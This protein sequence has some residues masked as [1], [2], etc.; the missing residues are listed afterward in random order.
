MKGEMYILKANSPNFHQ[1]NCLEDCGENL[2]F[3]IRLLLCP[4]IA[5]RHTSHYPNKACSRSYSVFTTLSSYP[6]TSC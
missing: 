3:G 6:D 4:H 2:H 5:F 1:E